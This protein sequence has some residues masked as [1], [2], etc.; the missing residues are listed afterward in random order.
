MNIRQINFTDEYFQEIRKIRKTVFYVEMQIPESVL[1]DKYDE[2]SDHFIFEHEHDV[3]GSVRLRRVEN[4]MKLE[5]MA[6]YENF[7]GKNFG[8]DAIS[9]IITHYKNKK[10]ILDSIYNI[11][12]FYKKSG[13]IEVGKIFDRVGLP[14]IRM[15]LSF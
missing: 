6:I 11:R 8:N 13:F 10:I 12:D 14:H 7:R 2:T 9:Q 4:N 3:I 15:E 5:R 1:F